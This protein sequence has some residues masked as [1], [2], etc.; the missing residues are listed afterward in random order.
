VE[1]PAFFPVHNAGFRGK[2]NTPRYW[3]QIPDLP[4]MMLNAPFLEQTRYFSEIKR[5]G[6]RGYF[7]IP[8]AAFLDSGG[9]QT[10]THGATFDP[11]RVLRI[12]EELGADIGTTVDSPILTQDRVWGVKYHVSQRA[13]ARTALLCLSKRRSVMLLYAVAH[14]NSPGAFGNLIR[15]LR[16]RGD[17]DG[18][19]LGGLAFRR[20]NLRSF[21]DII[22]NARKAAGDL[23]VHVLGV[24]GPAYI[25]LLVYLGVDT[26]DSS[27]YIIC[28]ANRKY[29]LPERGSIDFSKFQGQ[30][31]L[32][33]PC[34]ICA[35][36]MAREIGAKRDLLTL[37][38]LWALVYELRKLRW[39]IERGDLEAY[40]ESRFARMPLMRR[41]VQYARQRMRGL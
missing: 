29:F 3:A 28:G 39:E 13:N 30:S 33:C 18:F 38:N 35:Q 8:G 16:R 9:L 1:T 32:P 14:G 37:H 6:V 10:R 40:L 11:V 22:L 36:L 25:P 19:A 20:S 15:F 23:P 17:F 26:F 2:G 31:H 24:A 34:P 4:H 12:Q 27:S 21:V 5:A 7:G 41:A